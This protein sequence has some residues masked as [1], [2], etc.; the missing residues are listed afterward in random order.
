MFPNIDHH[1]L[2]GIYVSGLSV[3]SR[4]LLAVQNEKLQ[5]YIQ[6]RPM[7]ADFVANFVLIQQKCFLDQM[8]DQICAAS[9]S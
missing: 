2:C 6:Q 3:L 9:V 5:P 1:S 7:Q 8:Q 4:F